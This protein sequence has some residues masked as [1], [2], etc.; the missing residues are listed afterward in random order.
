M[1]KLVKHTRH[2]IKLLQNNPG[3][4][5]WNAAAGLLSLQNAEQFK[6]SHSHGISYQLLPKIRFRID[7]VHIVLNCILSG[8]ASPSHGSAAHKR[9]KT[10]TPTTNEAPIV[11]CC[12]GVDRAVARWCLWLCPAEF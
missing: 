3:P 1:E 2:H 7:T 5:N 9:I 12:G 4:D 11:N 6:F 8:E 10:F